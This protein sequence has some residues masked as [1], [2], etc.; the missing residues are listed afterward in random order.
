MTRPIHPKTLFLVAT[1]TLGCG[2]ASTPTATPAT[3]AHTSG[4][5]QA[6]LRE[7]E[8]HALGGAYVSA[9]PVALTSFG[10]ATMAG[11][12]GDAIYVL[13]GYHG[14]PHRYSREGQSNKLYR[15]LRTGTTWSWSELATYAEGTQGLALVPFENDLVAC[16]GSTLRNTIESPA[17]QHAS[18]ACYRYVSATNAWTPFAPLPTPRSSFDAAVLGGRIYAVGGW[19]ISGAASTGSFSSTMAVYADGA[20]TEVALPF[21]RRALAVAATSTH[22]IALGGMDASAA[23]SSA[24]DIFDPATGQWT[25]GPAYPGDAFGVSATAIGDVIFASGRDGIV[26]RYR[27]GDAAWERVTTLA[28]GRFFHRLARA[29][30]GLAVV[31]GIGSMTMDGRARLVEFVSLES[32]QR[33]RVGHVEIDFPGASRNRAGIFMLDDSLYVAGGNNSTGQHDFQPHN[34]ETATHRL[35]LPSLRWFEGPA[36]PEGRQS[37][38]SVT[39]DDSSQ[40][41]SGRPSSAPTALHH[42]SATISVGGFGHD[43]DG[44]RTYADAFVIRDGAPAWQTV[45]NALPRPRTQFGAAYAGDAL[46]VFGGLDYDETRPE[47]TQ[48]VH[49]DSVLRCPVDHATLE[50]E[51]PASPLGACEEI[52]GA[53]MPGTRRAFAGAV[54][55]GRYYMMGGMRDGFAPV[56]DCFAFTLATRTWEAFQCPPA[57]RISGEAFAVDGRLV[58]L[59]GTSRREGAE[60]SAPDRS[61]E[62]YDPAT[63]TWSTLIA[64][65]PVDTHQMRFVRHEHRILGFSSQQAEHRAQIVTIDAS[66]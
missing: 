36:L 2:N 9:M 62:V 59:G 6:P 31:G 58:L 3:A 63:Q 18:T 65:L 30:D 35:H 56:P 38:V 52:T 37:L 10:S 66:R 34:F 19:N 27:V 48:F 50:H 51:G 8:I 12:E 13:G 21:Q 40:G 22:L 39:H 49:L 5:E 41:G 28:E 11:P 14:E 4:A 55:E 33:E 15:L 45:R 54:L 16:G 17:D 60:A 26:H 64:E 7:S 57:V 20:W 25:S 32:A 44:S 23:L 61:V 47:D 53:V 46:W 42:P 1:A 29:A 43:G 24:L